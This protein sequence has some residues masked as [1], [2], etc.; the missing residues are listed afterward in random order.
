MLFLRSQDGVARMLTFV[1]NLGEIK[2]SPNYRTIK[3][4][5]RQKH[6]DDGD[7]IEALPVTNFGKIFKA[8]FGEVKKAGNHNDVFRDNYKIYYYDNGVET[9]FKELM[10]AEK[11]AIVEILEL[12]RIHNW[13]VMSIEKDELIDLSELPSYGYQSLEEYF[14]DE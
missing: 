12:G 13:A 5:L 9:N 1:Y 14:G 8:H 6:Y 7:V 2:N 3:E 11:Q 4:K 10:V